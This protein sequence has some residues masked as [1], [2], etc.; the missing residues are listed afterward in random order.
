[1]PAL[2]FVGV[3]GA[4]VSGHKTGSFGAFFDYSADTQDLPVALAVD[5]A[6][7]IYLSANA[8][9]GGE[10]LEAQW[11]SKFDPAGGLLWTR[12]IPNMASPLW[13]VGKLLALDG[14][15]HIYLAGVAGSPDSFATLIV[16]KLDAEGNELWRRSSPLTSGGHLY[17][18]ALAVA[19]DGNCAVTGF[20][21]S[22]NVEGSVSL[23]FGSLVLDSVA[24]FD[25]FT[26][27][28]DS[29]GR[30][31]WAASL[32]TENWDQPHGLTIDQ[33]GAVYVTGYSGGK[34]DTDIEHFFLE[35]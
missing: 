32:G 16:T 23:D 24:R 17:P 14:T 6:G 34:F 35:K 4:K 29:E 12:S 26:A 3:E 8:W 18:A 9:P 22:G 30:L 1:V 33:S 19:R 27:K 25:V 20:F 28:Y 7:N 21:T 5:P 31:L 13:P 2:H 11:V 10:V 15:G